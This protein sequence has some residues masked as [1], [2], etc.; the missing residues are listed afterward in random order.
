MA[1]CQVIGSNNEY[2]VQVTLVIYLLMLW[3]WSRK[4]QGKPCKSAYFPEKPM[5]KTGCNIHKFVVIFQMYSFW[6]NI[7][8]LRNLVI[9]RLVDFLQRSRQLLTWNVKLE[10]TSLQYNIV[11]KKNSPRQCLFGL[12]LATHLRPLLWRHEAAEARS[13]FFLTRVPRQTTL[14]LRL[15][16]NAHMLCKC[17]R[18]A[19]PVDDVTTHWQATTSRDNADVYE[20]ASLAKI[21]QA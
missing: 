6:W 7:L 17:R 13:T 5:R 21:N 1:V 2:A 9:Y 14:I 3:K 11:Q 18:H 19:R 4:R 16:V 12:L 10:Q 15:I 8:G 20:N